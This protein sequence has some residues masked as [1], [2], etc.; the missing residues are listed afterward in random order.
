MSSG[1]ELSRRWQQVRR[2]PG[3][4]PLRIKLITAVL[5]LVVIA[6]GAISIAGISLLRSYLLGQADTQLAD[7]AETTQHTVSRCLSEPRACPLIGRGET[8]SWLP[9]GGPMQ[10]IVV[11]VQNP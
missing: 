3:R 9:T 2:L 1:S 8:I 11:A 7:I 6:L 10:Q 4:T 5:A